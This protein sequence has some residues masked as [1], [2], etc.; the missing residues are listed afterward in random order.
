MAN[1]YKQKRKTKNKT[2]S[3]TTITQPQTQILHGKIISRKELR[4]KKIEISTTRY[5]RT[6]TNW[7]RKT[8][9]I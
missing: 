5:K 1:V 7:K 6:M 4:K 8:T 3:T 9:T 2:S